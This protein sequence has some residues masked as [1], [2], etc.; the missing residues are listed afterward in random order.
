[1]RHTAANMPRRWLFLPIKRGD[2]LLA[3]QFGMA[4][5]IATGAPLVA[6]VILNSWISAANG[7]PAGLWL[8]SM[9]GGLIVPQSFTW[10]EA[11]SVVQL[12]A[13]A[14]AGFDHR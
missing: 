5:T 14:A 1:M 9:L 4:E 10:G 6:R 7:D 2:V 3:T 12:D 8:M 11:A 13:H